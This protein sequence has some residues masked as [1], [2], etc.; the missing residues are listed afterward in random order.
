VGHDFEHE[1]VTDGMMSLNMRYWASPRFD[2]ITPDNPVTLKVNLDDPNSKTIGWAELRRGAQIERTNEETGARE[3]LCSAE[4]I[5]LSAEHPKKTQRLQLMLSK[6]ETLAVKYDT[7][8]ITVASEA[9]PKMQILTH[10]G[11]LLNKET[12]KLHKQLPAENS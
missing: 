2:E 10:N 3:K 9:A 4:L 8:D 5:E 7:T 12:N 6:L 1:T 11:Y